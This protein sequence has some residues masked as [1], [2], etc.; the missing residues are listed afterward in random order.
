MSFL[1]EELFLSVKSKS[2]NKWLVLF[3][4]RVLLK[5]WYLVLEVL[6]K[7]W[8]LNIYSQKLQAQFPALGT[9]WITF[10]WNTLS[11]INRLLTLPIYFHASKEWS[12]VKVFCE[13]QFGLVGYISLLHHLSFLI[14]HQTSKDWNSYFYSTLWKCWSWKMSN[15]TLHTSL[16]QTELTK[17]SW[18]RWQTGFNFISGPT[19]KG[20]DV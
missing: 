16:S 1:H 6:W 10:D 4:W 8:N 7:H 12:L 5:C 20:R 18:N 15:T 11:D 17:P 3:E 2:V 19:W 13:L 9:N 14:W